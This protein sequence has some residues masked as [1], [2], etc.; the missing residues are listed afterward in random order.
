MIYSVNVG[1][2]VLDVDCR[3]RICTGICNSIRRLSP[4]GYGFH[5]IWAVFV[6]IVVVRVVHIG[7]AVAY[8]S[9]FPIADILGIFV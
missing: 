1:D 5:I 6:S 9:Y 2:N 7:H 8:A 4:H 3:G